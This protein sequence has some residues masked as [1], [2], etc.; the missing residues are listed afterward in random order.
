M[1]FASDVAWPETEPHPDKDML[2]KAITIE[3]INLLTAPTE[4]CIFMVPYFP[5]ELIPLNL[6]H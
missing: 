2:M 6:L 5:S 3:L 4:V 1:V